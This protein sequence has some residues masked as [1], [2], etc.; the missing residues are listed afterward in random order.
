MA[1]LSSSTS[2]IQR[3]IRSDSRSYKRIK[4]HNTKWAMGTR[5]S[6]GV[7]LNFLGIDGEFRTGSKEQQAKVRPEKKKWYD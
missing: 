3:D 4:D 2:S 6:A 5:P 1:T 7:K